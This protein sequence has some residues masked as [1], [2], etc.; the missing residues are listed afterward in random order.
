MAIFWTNVQVDVQTALSTPAKTITAI[1]K[2]NPG[3]A[4]S[5]SHGFANGDYLVLTVAGMVELNGIVVRVAGVATDTFQL[6]GI[7]TT[8][9]NTFTSGT[10]QKI[11]FGQSMTT[12]QDLSVSGGEPEFADVTT[13]HDTLRKRTPTVKSPM[14]ISMNSLFAP[15]D[16][17]LTELRAADRAIT[18]RAIRLR[19]ASGEKIVFNSYV[20]APGVPT[21]QAGQAV[22]TPVALEVQGLPSVYST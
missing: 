2:A 18:T 13:I 7:D 4:S 20:S 14:S 22:Q 19:F 16:A 15:S 17:A 12:A 8:L 5:T 3:V 21:G 1:T 10:C 11:T 6:E 9:F